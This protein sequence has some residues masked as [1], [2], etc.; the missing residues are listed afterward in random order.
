[1]TTY[2]D[3]FSVDGATLGANWTARNF[4][5]KAASGIAVPGTAGQ[6]NINSYSAGVLAT[7]DHY[8]E[9]VM[10]T[11]VAGDVALLYVRSSNAGWLTAF[12]SYGAQWQILS[13]PS[14]AYSNLGTFISRDTT[15]ATVSW[16]A[17]DVI[18]F[19]AVGTTYTVTKNGAAI[20]DGL[21]W[22]DAGNAT[23]GQVDSSH[24]ESAIGYLSSNTTTVGFKS[25]TASDVAAT[26]PADFFQL[27]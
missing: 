12:C 6:Y 3:P 20:S 14:V 16:V 18:R 2:T 1:M 27:F 26:S 25:W 17:D 19:S 9:C 7:N 4:G 11:P 23:Y 15:A 5:L 10:G 8:T 21:S 24:R 22:T 13:A